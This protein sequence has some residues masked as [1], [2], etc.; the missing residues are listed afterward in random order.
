[1]RWPLRSPAGW[2]ARNPL[3]AAS[4][5]S[6][7]IVLLL[8]VGLT[9]LVFSQLVSLRAYQQRISS[10]HFDAAEQIA[11]SKVRQIQELLTTR[12]IQLDELAQAAQGSPATLTANWRQRASALGFS[13]LLLV[14]QARARVIAAALHPQLVGTSLEAGWLRGSA[15]TRAVSGLRP[16]NQLSVAPLDA[17]P[18]LPGMAAWLAVPLRTG[19][20][21]GLVLAGRLDASAF[22][23]V[24]DNRY[25]RLAHQARVQLVTERSQGS[26]RSW[27]P[28]QLTL[29]TP[30]QP[31][32]V[33]TRA[34]SLALPAQRRSRGDGGAG[35]VRAS[36]G[37]LLLAAWRQ[38]PYSDVQVLVTIPEA[39]PRRQSQAL[40]LQLLLLLA[41][42]AVLV[43]V[44]GVLLGRR[45]SR[46]LQQL[47]RAI[48]DFDP[49][50]E[51]SL[52]PVTVRGGD[53][54]ASLAGTINAMTLR[55]QERTATLR[56]A[57]EQLDTYIQTVQT[58]LLALDLEGRITMLNRS[59]CSLLGIDPG[60]WSRADWLGGWVEPADRAMLAEWLRRAAQRQLPA[61][62]QLEYAVRSAARGSRL[63]RWH[64]S[65]L[66][67][68]DGE[69]I[70]LL[71][72]GEDITDRHAQELELEQAR[73]DAE[74]ANAA[75]SDFLSRMS[76]ELRTPMNAIIGM[77]HLALRTDL[78]TRQRDYLQKISSAGQTL[79]GIIND[80]LDFSKIEAGKLTL[81]ATD[82]A[83]DSILADVTNL[84]ADKVFA[85]GVELL[86][87][88]DEDVPAQLNGDPLRLTQVLLNLLSN[89]AKFTEKGQ[90]T[91]RVSL[92]ERRPERV[93]LQFAV[94]DTGIGMSAEQISHLFEAFQQA[95]SSTTRRYGGTGLGLSICQRLLALMDGSISVQSRPGEGSCFTA[96]AC[97][98]LGVTAAPTL[99]PQALNQLRVLVVDDNPA[100]VEVMCGLLEHLP[101]RCETARDGEQALASLQQAARDGDAYGLL[102]LDWQLGAP[103]DGLQVAER[104]R[105]D[106]S[107]PQPRI[108]MVTAY[109]S[110]DLCQ[111]APAGLIDACLSK[112]VRPSDLI[113]TL[114]G[115]FSGTAPG[116]PGPAAPVDD[117]AHWGLQGLQVLLV[118]DN[119]INQQI[120]RE[121]LEIVGVQV[122]LAGNGLE[123]LEWLQAHS[124]P[125]DPSQAELCSPLPCDGVLLDL[126]MPVMDGWEC[127]RRIRA[128]QRWRQLPLL[129]MTAHA[130]QQE[131][132]RCLAL[133]MQDHIPKPID[134]AVLYGRLRHWCGSRGSRL[135]AAQ[136]LPDAV[137]RREPRA[138][139][140][141]QGLWPEGFD[142]SGALRR[143][144]G[145][146][147]LYRRLLESLVH[148]QA[149]AAERLEAL[150]GRGDLPEAQRLVHTL[151]GVAANL[152]AVALADAA[153]CLD[154][155]LRRGQAPA[156]L[157]QHLA[158]QLRLS[159]ERIGAA[160]AMPSAPPQP[161]DSDNGLSGPSPTTGP[162]TAGQRQLLDRLDA[163]LEA[164]DG[165]ALDL[166]ER[167]RQALVAIVGPQGYG[168]LNAEL[169]RFDFSAARLQLRQHCPDS[170][171]AGTE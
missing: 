137:S 13:E 6:R 69:V 64:L 139:A 47:H 37:S 145:N 88:V 4:L 161:A 163:L 5:R 153:S 55:I 138:G 72:S 23:E 118:E 165:E 67:G 133:G 143:V 75:K 151:K 152:G 76:H 81:E 63:M 103:P 50:D 35:L 86:F 127:A 16:W 149:D 170:L 61:G 9:P 90:I 33:A 110:E 31:E 134:P 3:A 82:F 28:L 132:E 79:L 85:K 87:S 128:E 54:I 155:E 164:A 25:Q 40:S 39:E 34:G 168:A 144:A 14:D 84:I 114:V 115:L 1:M 119:P 59:G 83:L 113:D 140:T 68:A 80:I 91:L 171:P 58:T 120:A 107:L 148:T 46:P 51:T 42:T 158:E 129:A 26:R 70:G 2:R 142:T 49:E 89:A 7:L 124:P 141:P 169:M 10:N 74:Q 93:Q 96:R 56:A 19:A 102:L 162:L 167:E 109:G 94:Q 22:L 166:V 66:E 27:Q 65:L 122:S 136:P 30:A 24:L 78:D 44:A 159:L 77:T 8:A 121:L 15:L 62:G 98:G 131:R 156:A 160:L 126:N 101:L 125:A 95:E 32:L 53:E 12:G 99:V 135:P 154:A 17:D 123:A 100:A 45:L 36:G 106:P 150:L 108:V 116:R 112:P 57:K 73:R 48:Q 117:P 43:G 92:L 105:A 41:G 60:S 11:A 20:A 157:R 38:I 146:E 52:H 147:Q 71:G 21:D 97:F 111:R 18:S 130:L 29:G 104:L